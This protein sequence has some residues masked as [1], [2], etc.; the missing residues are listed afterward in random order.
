MHGRRR[1]ICKICGED[2]IHYGLGMC[3]PCLRKW[4]RQTRP[5]YYLRT[6]WGEIKRRS[7]QKVPNR[8]YVCFGQKF[9]TKD[10]FVN[11]FLT[12]KK[13]LSLY[14][15]WQEHDFKRGFAPSI[16]RIDPTKGYEIDNLQFLSNNE[17]TRKDSIIPTAVL[18]VEQDILYTFNSVAEAA[19]FLN[20]GSGKLC[21]YRDNK[22]LYKK[23]YSIYTIEVTD[24]E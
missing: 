22:V 4:K 8:E 1:V 7:T 24:E 10:E 14:K 17:N 21:H 19:N 12:D 5:I 6:C 3:S 20:I 2:K 13:F 9:C 18:D 16:D 11:R 15:S 23:I